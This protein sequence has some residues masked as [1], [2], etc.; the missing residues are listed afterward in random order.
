MLANPARRGSL[1]SILVPA[2]IAAVVFV[3]LYGLVAYSAGYNE[4]RMSVLRFAREMWKLEQWQHCILVGPLIAVIIYFQRHRLARIPVQGTWLGLPIILAS[5]FIYWFGFEADIVYFGYVSAQILVAG[6]I[7]FL[8]GWRWMKALAFPWFFMVFLWPLLF[9]GDMVAFPLTLLMSKLGAA[10]LNI[11]GVS[12]VLSG[13]SILSAPDTLT[14]RPMGAL[15]SVEVAEACS[16]INSLF[17]LIMV[18]ALYGHFAVKGWKRQAIIFLAAFPMAIFGNLCRILILTFGTIILGPG[19]A[20]G[21]EDHPSFFHMMAGYLVY[22]F[23]LLGIMGVGKLV[24][25][26]WPEVIDRLREMRQNS[27]RPAPPPPP[28]STN[29]RAPVGDLY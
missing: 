7:L 8:F 14:G 11:L 2:L 1:A 3:V 17:A 10:V 13:N 5:L 28:R 12:T 6:L 16:G 27:N 22:G 24:N 19:I 20:I 9:M 18:S 23:A 25:L 4:T 21:T 26:N 15:F 29:G